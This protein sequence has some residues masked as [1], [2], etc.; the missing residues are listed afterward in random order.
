MYAEVKF[1]LP[2]DPQTLIIPGNAVMIRAEGPK[3]LVVDAKEII[4]S[5]AVKLG[6]DLGER[7]EIV[8][9]LAP[10]ESVVANP[11]DALR[12]GT[13]V[14]VQAQASNQPTQPAKG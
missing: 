1:T 13:E 9:G 4:R 14:K 10:N 8:S 3:V 7:V 6:R 5:R 11:T 2:Q 12:D